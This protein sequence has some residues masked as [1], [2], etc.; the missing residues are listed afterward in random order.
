MDFNIEDLRSEIGNNL[1]SEI[2][3]VSREFNTHNKN[4]ER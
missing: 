3:K 2:K 1:D 4:V